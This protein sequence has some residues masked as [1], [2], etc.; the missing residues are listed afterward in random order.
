MRTLGLAV[1]VV[2]SLGAVLALMW[3]LARALRGKVNASG[4][5]ALELLARLPMTRGSSVAVV[6]VADQI[7]VLGVTESQV[8]VLTVADPAQLQQEMKR[9]DSTSVTEKVRRRLPKLAARENVAGPLAGSILS[10]ES[11]RRAM[12]LIRERT[13][14]R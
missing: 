10:P 3:L 4:A 8:T 13:V 14:R 11:W 1:Q 12:A 9:A 5:G 7:L 2:L 6:R